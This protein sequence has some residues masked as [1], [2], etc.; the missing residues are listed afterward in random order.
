MPVYVR[1]LF[2]YKMPRKRRD[3]LQIFHEHLLQPVRSTPGQAPM[4]TI[5]RARLRSSPAY[6][7]AVES[8]CDWNHGGLG[9]TPPQST[10]LLHGPKHSG[11]IEFGAAACGNATANFVRTRPATGISASEASV[12]GASVGQAWAGQAWAGQAWAGASV[13]GASASG[14]GVGGSSGSVAVLAKWPRVLHIRVA[15]AAGHKTACQMGTSA[16]VVFMGRGSAECM[17]GRIQERLAG[18]VAVDRS[19]AKRFTQNKKTTTT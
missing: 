15:D 19:L 10:N 17:G 7:D 16:T 4:L 18:K 9:L 5:S 11:P 3:V 14:V 8:A 1:S 6:W 13:A 2:A 12:G